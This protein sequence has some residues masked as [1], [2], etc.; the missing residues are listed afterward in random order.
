M[1]G[2]IN[3]IYWS[4]EAIIQA[5]QWIIKGNDREVKQLLQEYKENRIKQQEE[6]IKKLRAV[7]QL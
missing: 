7:I 2:I 3:K 4:K 5:N 1:K 6:E